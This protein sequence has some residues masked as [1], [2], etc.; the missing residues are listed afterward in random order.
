MDSKEFSRIRHYLGKKQVQLAQLLCV[1]PKAIQS[2]E[3]GWRDIPSYIE[4]QILV[5]LSLKRAIDSSIKPCWDIL[6]CPVE[7]R[8]NCSTWEFNAGNLCWFISGTFCHGEYQGSWKNKI[9]LCRQ[10]EVFLAMIPPLI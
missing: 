7:W 2:F 6:N 3:Q 5:L 1:S 9:G 4:R 8:K 10:C